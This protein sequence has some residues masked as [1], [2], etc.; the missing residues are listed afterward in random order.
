M[1]SPVRP[2]NPDYGLDLEHSWRE[3]W[4]FT[5]PL[6]F[7]HGSMGCTPRAVLQQQEGI[8]RRVNAGREEFVREGGFSRIEESRKRLAAFVGAADGNLVLTTNI[9]ESLNCVLKSLTF[10]PGDEVLVTNHIYVNYPALIE[11]CARRQGFRVVRVD[12]PYRL[13]TEEEIITP[14][15]AQVGVNTRLAIIDHISSPT[16][17]IFPV[18]L[19]VTLLDEKGV[20]CFVDGAHAPGQLDLDLELLGA[21]YYG[22]N[23]HKWLCAPLSSGFLYVRPDKQADIV[24]AVGSGYATMENDFVTRFSWQ[25]VIDFVPRLMIPETLRTMH[26]LHPSGWSGIYQRNHV[27]AVAVRRLLCE[28]LGLEAPVPENM[29]GAMFTLPL[30]P[31]SFTPE[32]MQKSPLHRGY[33]ALVQS[34]GFGAIFSQ[35][36]DDYIVR[37]TAHLYNKLSDYNAL[38]DA[39]AVFIKEHQS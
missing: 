27:L 16:A 26:D 36:G 9:T 20:D 1:T 14:I 12:I 37:V 19:L 23:N 34:H 13:A 28:R 2:S 5:R 6:N 35:F 22:A 25:G 33:D 38:A 32:E 8:S 31:L 17:M 39:L 18:A 11:E 7:N 4:D 24:P 3:A 30:G 10:A 15:M 29:I 21:A